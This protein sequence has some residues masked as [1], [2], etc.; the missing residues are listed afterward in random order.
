VESWQTVLD[1]AIYGYPLVTSNEVI[2][3][4]TWMGHLYAINEATGSVT[5]DLKLPFEHCHSNPALLANGTLVV[6]G[7]DGKVYCFGD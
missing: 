2:Y 6:T 1:S 7:A 5:A 4:T 3:A